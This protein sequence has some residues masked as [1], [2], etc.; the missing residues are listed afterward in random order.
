[1]VSPITPNREPVGDV[2]TTASISD[3]E[4]PGNVANYEALNLVGAGAYGSVY[5]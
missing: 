1:M 5:R 4:E 2:S 3:Q